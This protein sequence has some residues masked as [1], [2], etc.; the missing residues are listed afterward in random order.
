MEIFEYSVNK[1]SNATAVFGRM[2]SM[3]SCAH[4]RVN[5]LLGRVIN[6]PYYLLEHGLIDVVNTQK[7]K[8][9]QF[10]T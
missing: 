3:D 1:R 10:K 8:N 4:N 2:C 5:L 9:L 6:H 7:K